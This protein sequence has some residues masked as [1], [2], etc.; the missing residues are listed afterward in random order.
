MI[1][2]VRSSFGV[3]QRLRSR[4][5]W[6]DADDEWDD[7]KTDTSQRVQALD[8]VTIEVLRLHL[9][10]QDQRRRD[11]GAAWAGSQR[12][13]TTPPV[14]PWIQAGSRKSLHASWSATPPSETAI[15][16]NTGIGTASPLAIKSP[17]GPSTPP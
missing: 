16:R 3:R 7:T 8:T 14:D 17:T 12:L 10:R 1:I 13:F 6:V 15:T 9:A 5:L 2:A 4:T 11:L